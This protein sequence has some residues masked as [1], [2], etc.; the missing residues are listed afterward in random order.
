M[1]VELWANPCG[2]DLRYYC[3]NVLRERLE[4]LGNLMGTRKDKKFPSPTPQCG[5]R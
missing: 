4:N 2:I 3:E 5:F 1:R